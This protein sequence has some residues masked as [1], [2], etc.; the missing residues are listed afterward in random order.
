ML[1]TSLLINMSTNSSNCTTIQL[2][3]STNFKFICSNIPA[4]DPRCLKYK[5]VLRPFK[6]LKTIVCRHFRVPLLNEFF[7]QAYCPITTLTLFIFTVNH[8]YIFHN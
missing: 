8:I 2:L 5:R 3:L 7:L 1:Q 6:L 4:G